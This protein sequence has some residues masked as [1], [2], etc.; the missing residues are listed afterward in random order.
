MSTRPTPWT[1]FQQRSRLTRVLL[2]VVGAVVGVNVV[3]SLGSSMLGGAQPSGPDSSSYA[4]TE[5]GLA[6]W[7]TLLDRNGHDV[8]RLRTRLG[9]ADLPAAATL[10]IADPGF[11]DRDDLDAVVDHLQRGGRVVAAGTGIDTLA[12]EVRADVRRATSSDEVVPVVGSAPEVVGLSQLDAGAGARFDHLRGLTPLVADRDGAALV[13]ATDHGTDGGR[14]VLLATSEPLR[15]ERLARA[16]NAAF[17][18]QVVGAED[19]PVYFAETFHGYGGDSS[20]WSALPARWRLALWLLLGAVL[21]WMWSLGRR[22]GPV[23]PTER[24]LAPPRRSYVD[25]MAAGL[26]RG[27]DPSQVVA[28]VHTEVRRR[29]RTRTGLSPDHDDVAL[30][31]AAGLTG[32]PVDDVLRALAVPIDDQHLIAVC[33]AATRVAAAADGIARP[34]PGADP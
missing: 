23:E 31:Q 32:V 25:A 26:A 24:A 10:V 21:V 17:A 27:H 8:V 34:Q 3:L 15:N 33:A 13:A 18:L 19:A 12:G 7:S 4:T 6:A 5:T 22:F 1:W 30:A 11:L 29:L 20:G 9:E 28:P 2:G 14:L 16:D